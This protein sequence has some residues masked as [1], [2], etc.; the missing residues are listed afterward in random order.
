MKKLFLLSAWAWVAIACSS[1]GSSNT[2]SN[3]AANRANLVASNIDANA[4]AYSRSENAYTFAQIS[5][6]AIGLLPSGKDAREIVGKTVSESKLWQNKTFDG[7]L[8]KLMG[9]D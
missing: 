1:S 9:F 7:R 4:N 8:R 3:A 2:A 5:N 6:Q